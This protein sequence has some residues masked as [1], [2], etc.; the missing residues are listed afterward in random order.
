MRRPLRD[1]VDPVARAD[2]WR[3]SAARRCQTQARSST[4]A[5]RQALAVHSGAAVKEL[6]DEIVSG[7]PEGGE[8]ELPPAPPGYRIS[9]FL[10]EDP[11]GRM[12]SV[13]LKVRPL[14][15]L[16]DAA[17][18]I[19]PARAR[20]LLAQV[21]DALGVVHE[22]GVVHSDVNMVNILVAEEPV[23]EH[24]FITGFWSPP[25][26]NAAA[27]TSTRSAAF[28]SICKAVKGH[29]RTARE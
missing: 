12:A 4:I 10:R 26:V 20:N 8:Q 24:A 11:W 9:D 19:D 15:Q 3:S 5:R 22:R 23:P 29:S 17:H 6:L 21:A 18:R 16:R 25:E 7:R 27:P 1:E 14:S 28:C 13:L 2:G